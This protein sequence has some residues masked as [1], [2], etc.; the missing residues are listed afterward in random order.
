MSKRK[1]LAVLLVG[2]GLVLASVPIILKYNGEHEAQTLIQEFEE[3]TEDDEGGKKKPSSAD[4]EDE[5]EIWQEG[6]I[7]II[8]IKSIGIRYPII[9]GAGS[10]ALNRGIG[11]EPDTA[12]I[13]EKG[14]C[15]LCGHNGSRHGTFFTPLSQVELGDVVEVTDREGKLHKYEIVSTKVIAPNDTSIKEQG[16]E[17]ILT[18]FTCA[19]RGTR[20]FV[21]VCIPK[22]TNER[23]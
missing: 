1:I 21:C 7:G 11:H 3:R 8:E 17:E 23:K 20:R 10:A 15:V 22:I 18:L 16:D 14:N 12:A 5:T 9:E 13:G 19:N 6:A 2:I 4:Q